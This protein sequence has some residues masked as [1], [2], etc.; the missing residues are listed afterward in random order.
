MNKISKQRFKGNTSTKWFFVYTI[1]GRIG[2]WKCWFLRRGENRRNNVLGAL[3]GREPTTNSTKSINRSR[4]GFEPRPHWWEASALVTSPP[5][6]YVS[7]FHCLFLRPLS[8]L[9]LVAFCFSKFHLN[10][11]LLSGSP[12]IFTRKRQLL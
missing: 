2:I 6:L 3:I 10:I 11:K 4:T 1:P 9:F 12:I 8:P 5:L 7:N